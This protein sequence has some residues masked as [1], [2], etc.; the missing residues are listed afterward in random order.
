MICNNCN[1]DK[2]TTNFY[3][4]RKKCKECLIILRNC[5]HNLRKCRCKICKLIDN[6]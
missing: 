1:I 4:K 3:K 2:D 6:I 5:I